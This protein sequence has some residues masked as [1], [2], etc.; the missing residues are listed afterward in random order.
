MK[1]FGSEKKILGKSQK[2]YWIEKQVVH[3]AKLTFLDATHIQYSAVK[4]IK[5]ARLIFFE[6]SVVH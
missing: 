6:D 3:T 2:F 1:I 4:E 5:Y